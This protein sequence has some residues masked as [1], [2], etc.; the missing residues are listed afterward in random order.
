MRVLHLMTPAP[1]GGAERVVL[2]L[3]RIL[4][5]RGIDVHIGAVI[6]VGA[7]GSDQGPDHPF[8]RHVHP[9]V[10]CHPIALPPRAYLA[11]WRAVRRL[12][13]ELSPTVVHTHGYRADV[14]AGSAARRA[15]VPVVTTVHGFTGG[16][17]RNR[18]YEWLQR[19]SFR[20]FH[21][22]V[23]VSRPL[24]LELKDG[25][26]PSACLQH[27]PNARP[28]PRAL[29]SP[30]AAREAAGVGPAAFHL[31]WVGRMSRE[32]GPDVMLEAVRRLSEGGGEGLHVTFIGDGPERPELEAQTRE[33]GL[34]GRVRWLGSVPDATALMPGMDALALS[35]RTEGTPIVALEAMGLGV[36]LVATRVGGVP[37]L[38]GDDAAILVPPEDPTAL[39]QA[40]QALR[41]DPS[42]RRRLAERAQRRVQEVAS[43]ERWAERYLEIY[44]Q[45]RERGPVRAGARTEVGDP[46]ED[47]R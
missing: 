28:L 18:L 27:I 17:G 21:G 9:S 42:L 30:E 12:I 33:W 2:D 36:P 15:G 5:R 41:N 29:P 10:P 14:V 16:G 6:P 23:A 3:T 43:P 4:A 47:Q 37:D 31:G 44:A 13:R 8:L 39:A 11:E 45:V 25:G 40:L 19:R 35:S 22:V 24:M 20:R 32:K 34:E 26:V 46:G 7:G 38:T 1:V